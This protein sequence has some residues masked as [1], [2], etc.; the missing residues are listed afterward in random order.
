M[1]T[2]IYQIGQ[3]GRDVKI[4]NKTKITISIGAVIIV[5]IL[6]I[7]F[8]GSSGGVERKIVGRWQMVDSDEI[9]EFTKD[10]QLLRLT[11]SSDGATITYTVDGNRVYLNVDILWAS[12]TVSADVEVDSQ[13]LLLTGFSDP[14]DIFGADYN[15]EWKFVKVK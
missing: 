9:Y 3:A 8:L 11:G 14:D 15:D 2:N 12:A 4:G 1:S 6:V 5:A 13:N 7:V 10:G